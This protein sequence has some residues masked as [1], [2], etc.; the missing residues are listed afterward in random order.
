MPRRAPIVRLDLQLVQVLECALYFGF[1]FGITHMVASKGI[2]RVDLYDA[3]HRKVGLSR[4]DFA[5][6]MESVLKEISDCIVRGETV[7]L[8]GFGTFTVKK[9]SQ[10]PGRNPRTGVDVIIEPRRVV[11]FKASPIMKAQMNAKQPVSRSL[12]AQVHAD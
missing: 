8:A 4:G 7:K 2:T 5:D 9:K 12:S 11:V 10:R 6:L 1:P 3:V